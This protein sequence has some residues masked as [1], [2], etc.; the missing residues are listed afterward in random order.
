LTLSYFI[1][2]AEL[3]FC[4][5]ILLNGEKFG[6]IEYSR[7]L[8]LCAGIA[9]LT[10]MFWRTAYNVVFHDQTHGHKPNVLIV[11]C[12]TL[13]YLCYVSMSILFFVLTVTVG[14]LHLSTI[15]ESNLASDTSASCVQ[16][17]STIKQAN[18]YFNPHEK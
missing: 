7:W 17:E 12:Q 8:Y 6:V 1:I 4:G 2:S 11:T 3:L 5:Y 9:A 14:F 13:F 18:T 15:A 10:G 16:A